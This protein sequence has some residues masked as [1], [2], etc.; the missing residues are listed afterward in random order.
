LVR[1]RELGPAGYLVTAMLA[2]FGACEMVVTVPD[3]LEVAGATVRAALDRAV[4]REDAVHGARQVLAEKTLAQAGVDVV[5]GQRL[6]ERT[7]AQVEVGVDAVLGKRRCP[8]VQAAVLGPAVEAGAAALCA[9]EHVGEP[10]VAAG[11]DP[12]EPRQPR[13]VP[14]E[15]DPAAAELAAEE[16]LARARLGLVELS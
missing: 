15:L 8:D 14:A 11:E 5:P 12:F 13:I 1:N 2:A 10:A 6:V 16:R 9:L 3:L 7:P 4:R